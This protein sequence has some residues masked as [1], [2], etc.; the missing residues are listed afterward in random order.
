MPSISALLEI[1]LLGPPRFLSNGRELRLERKKALALGAYLADTRRHVRRE[2]LAGLFWPE[3]DTSRGKA[4]LRTVLSELRSSLPESCF[5]TNAGEVWL[6]ADGYTSDVFALRAAADASL[7]LDDRRRAADLW[8]GGF[9][10]G[11]LLP[12]CERFTD[13]QFY[14]AEVYKATYALI[15]NDLIVAMVDTG[16]MDAAIAYAR[17]R[18][19]LDPIDD[20]TCRTLMSLYADNGNR[21]AALR[22]FEVYTERLRREFDL[23]PE[24][25]VRDLA[26]LIRRRRHRSATPARQVAAVKPRLAVLPFRSGEDSPG[27]AESL[28]ALEE[29]VVGALARQ[30]QIQLISRTSTLRYRA[31]TKSIAAIALELHADYVLECFLDAAEEEPKASTHLVDASRDTVVAAGRPVPATLLNSIDVEEL[32][33]PVK[34]FFGAPVGLPVPAVAVHRESPTQEPA[35]QEGLAVDVGAPWRLRG[36]HLMRGDSAE[37]FE[38]ALIAYRRALDL[39][40]NDAD[41]WAGVAAALA[42]LASNNIWARNPAEA[43][44]EALAAVE[45]ALAADPSQPT[46]LRVRGQLRCV[47]QRDFAGAEED[48]LAARAGD[49]NDP[50]ILVGYA[51]MLTYVRRIDEAWA[52]IQAAYSL[53]PA[54]FFVLSQLYWVGVASGRYRDAER[55]IDELESIVPHPFIN[56]W[57]RAVVNN[58]VGRPEQG[59][60]AM[61]R[62]LPLILNSPRAPLAHILSLSYALVGRSREADRLLSQLIEMSGDRPGFKVPI[63]AVYVAMQQLDPAYEWLEAA[64]A[65][66][67]ADVLYMSQVP[68]FAPLFDSDRYRAILARAGLPE[69]G[70]PGDSP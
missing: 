39:N 48:F 49:T 24:D 16:T 15:L 10:A 4:A 20:E 23:P 1:K 57:A 59:I 53:D 34:E 63:A 41:A 61:E 47:I 8:E 12:D 26:E 40:S 44:P 69:W 37:S 35:S 46:A 52:T 6:E 18:L 62:S 50:H 64:V 21:A 51:E 2:E 7:P 54:D 5:K 17:R 19:E 68:A 9:L 30:Q 43:Y 60:A 66:G 70:G 38:Q 42:T 22:E 67:D 14:E 29:A 55:A 56:D 28:A 32:I 58:L 36:R 25:T 13:W 45:R 27:A 11:F 33:R 31:T 65:A 3:L